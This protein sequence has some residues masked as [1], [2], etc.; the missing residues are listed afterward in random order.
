M[1]L[2]PVSPPSDFR[3]SLVATYDNHAAEREERGEDGWRWRL[4]ESFLTRLPERARLLEVGAGVGYTAC[5]FADRGVEVVA[6][7]L[8][9]AQV[10]LCRAKGLEAYV[11]DMYELGFAD[12][13]FDAV[14]AMNCLLHVPDADLQEVLIGIHR[15][16]RPGGWFQIGLWGGID[17]EGIFEDDFYKP[18]R[19]F[20]F[21]S[22]EELLARVSEVFA[23]ESFEVLDLE[24]EEDARLH[25]QSVVARRPL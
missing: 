20:S 1:E 16:L 10:E 19:F 15:V 22:D 4:A 5:W 6:T 21:R 17:D 18:N 3:A 12:G 9:P 2:H 25:L 8:S 14:W 13:S 7:D 23:V 11:R 24:D